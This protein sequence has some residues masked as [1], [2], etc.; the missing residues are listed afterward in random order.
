MLARLDVSEEVKKRLLATRAELDMTS[1]LHDI[2]LCQE[3]LDAIA[4]R[5]QPLIIKTRG[6]YATIS[7]EFTT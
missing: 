1:L 7:G 5:R 2:L 4:K 6:S 3:Y